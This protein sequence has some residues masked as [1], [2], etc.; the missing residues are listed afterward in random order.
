MNGEEYVVPEGKKILI[1]VGGVG[2]TLIHPAMFD[3]ALTWDDAFSKRAE[4]FGK[5]P[6]AFDY[7]SIVHYRVLSES[8]LK[9][10]TDREIAYKLKQTK[11]AAAK[12]SKKPRAKKT[13]VKKKKARA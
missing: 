2:K 3:V 5:R 9:Q 8:A 6:E 4:M 7:P 11:K 10:F 12:A 1:T 13:V